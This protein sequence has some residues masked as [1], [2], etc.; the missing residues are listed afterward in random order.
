VTGV[1]LGIALIVFVA[2][3]VPDFSHS[4]GDDFPTG[5]SDFLTHPGDIV[6][7]GGAQRFQ[8][9]G[10]ISTRFNFVSG[11]KISIK[12]YG[13]AVAV[14]FEDEGGIQFC[15]SVV[16]TFK[17]CY[18]PR[19]GTLVLESKTAAMAYIKITQAPLE[20]TP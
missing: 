11:T 9:N 12:S 15:Q 19:A 17:D 10:S 3:S 2:V 4:T 20:G 8:V 1:V 16:G 6:F 14:K 7:L 13:G 18:L 5:L